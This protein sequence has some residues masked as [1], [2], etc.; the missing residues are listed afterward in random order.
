VVKLLC[1]WLLSQSRSYFS[2]R[3]GPFG[4][5]LAVRQQ[6]VYGYHLA[7]VCSSLSGDGDRQR[8]EDQRGNVMAQE[9]DNIIGI[10]LNVV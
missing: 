4:G 9:G 5:R 6:R 7:V 8:V 10:R 3:L 2:I 1:V